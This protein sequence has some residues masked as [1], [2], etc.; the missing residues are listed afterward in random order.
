M[1]GYSAGQVFTASEVYQAVGGWGI[2]RNTIYAVLGLCLPD[3]DPGLAACPTA[4][5]AAHPSPPDPL[6]PADAAIRC[7]DK[8]KKMLFGRVTKP[9]KTPGRPEHQFVMPSIKAVCALLK[10]RPGTSDP[11]QPA[12]LASNTVYRQALHTALIRRRPGQY[13]RSW[14]GARLGISAESCRRYER[15]MG[16]VVQ[17]VYLVYPLNWTV[18]ES[19]VPDEPLAGTFLEDAAGKR[20]P[21][22]LPIARKLLARRQSIFF[23]RQVIQS[24]WLRFRCQIVTNW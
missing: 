2:G 1:Q 16:I 21:P 13:S 19:I 15:R 14:Q 17:P 6:N 18:L 4:H 24:L 11:L 23:K 9:G 12:D 8:T 3:D 7:A 5:P 10:V 22:L 20:Y